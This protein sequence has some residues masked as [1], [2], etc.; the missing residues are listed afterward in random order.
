MASV[1]DVSTKLKFAIETYDYKKSGRIS[2]EEL[3]AVLEGEKLL[4]KQYSDVVCNCHTIVI[5][6]QSHDI[7][8]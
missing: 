5:V 6:P 8:F 4:H 7:G 2:R 1:M 3:V